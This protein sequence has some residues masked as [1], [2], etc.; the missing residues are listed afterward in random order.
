MCLVSPGSKEHQAD[1]RLDGGAIAETVEWLGEARDKAL[2][3]LVWVSV[4]PRLSNKVILLSVLTWLFI[5]QP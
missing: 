2:D 4:L 1:R 3:S 5:T